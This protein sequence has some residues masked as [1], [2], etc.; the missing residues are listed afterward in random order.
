MQAT[1]TRTVAL[2]AILDEIDRWLLDRSADSPTAL[3]IFVLA[4]VARILIDRWQRKRD[5]KKKRKRKES[6]HG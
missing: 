3:L 6:A 4:F 1:A 5:A 2:G